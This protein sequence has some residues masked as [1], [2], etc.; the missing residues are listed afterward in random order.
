MF[1]LSDILHNEKY[2]RPNWRVFIKKWW[3]DIA[4]LIINVTAMVLI[5][6][7][8]LIFYYGIIII[9]STLTVHLTIFLRR[10]KMI[11]SQYSQL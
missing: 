4:S 2:F 7:R 1:S 6:T 10:R 8:V 3:K 5:L 9:A 11:R